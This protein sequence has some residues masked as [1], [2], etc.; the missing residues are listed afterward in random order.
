MP[1]FTSS[2]KALWRLALPMIFSN[3]TVPLLGLVDTAVIGHLDS[4]VFL[5]GV[6]VGATA[7]SFLFMLLL[8]LRMSTTGLTAQ[9]FGAKNPQALARAL[10]QPLLL[11]L[12]AGVMI[13]LFRTPLIELA[14]HIVGGNDAVLVQARR[15]LE[16]RWLSAPASLAN[17]V[18]LGW[19]LGVQY[20]RAP[21]ILLVVGN[22][23]NIALDLWLV[24]GLHMNVQ[25]AALATVIAEYV[26]LLIGLMMVRK[27][28][29]LRGVSLDMLKQ[30]WRG[31][32]RRLLA[33]N[34]DIMLRSL[35]LQLCFGAIT[36]S[37]ARLGS[38][39]IAVNAVLMT[40][41]TF[42]AYALDGFAYAVEAHSGQAYG[43]RDGSK[44]LDV[45]RAACRQS[46]IV[47]LLF[48]TVYALAGEHIV[49]LLTSLPQIQLLA[50]RYLIWQVVLPLVGVWCYLLDG[51][52]IGATRAAEM[53][54]SMAVAAGGF[55][56]TLFALPVL[57]NHGLWLAL[58]VFLALRGLS[59]SFIWRRHWREG[60]WFARS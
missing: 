15:F 55:A 33:L 9:A 45:W 10:I 14:L 46:G 59:L 50:D 24:M 20:A 47:A 52:F 42:T 30:A 40:L 48:S 49:A 25:G 3:I 44:L 35:L 43:A 1:L 23:L 7:T 8:F 39:I 22:I 32:V 51:M 56:L 18:L 37:G 60:T 38:D 27:V 54:N 4:P 21:V 6:A 41:L 2:D 13:V 26:T 29:H 19:L 5:G 16:I 17:L 12:G 11:A 36:V 28:L 57:G 31:N 58:T 34:R 53:R